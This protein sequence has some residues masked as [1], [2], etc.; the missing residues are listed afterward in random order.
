MHLPI[1]PA[2]HGARQVS[3]D[4]S[5][6]ERRPY[7][8]GG[9]GVIEETRFTFANPPQIGEDAQAR[10]SQSRSQLAAGAPIG[11]ASIKRSVAMASASS[12]SGPVPALIHPALSEYPIRTAGYS[13]DFPVSK[14]AMGMADRIPIHWLT[15]DRSADQRM[16]AMRSCSK[17]PRSRRKLSA[18]SP[19]NIRW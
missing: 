4:Q 2:T 19:T 13:P 7:P 14:P 1:G 8:D 3:S 5:I 16:L 9:E 12:S 6:Q 10:G 17:R 18:V 15:R 11:P